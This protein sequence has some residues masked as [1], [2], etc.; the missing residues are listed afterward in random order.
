MS[1][2]PTLNCDFPGWKGM[3]CPDVVLLRGVNGKGTERLGCVRH[4]TDLRTWL[5][6]TGGGRITPVVDAVEAVRRR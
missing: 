3:P 4:G 6:S 2:I 1:L 5:R